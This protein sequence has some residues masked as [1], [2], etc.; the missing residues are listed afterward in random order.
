MPGPHTFPVGDAY[1]IATHMYPT[2]HTVERG[3]A[4]RDD[5]QWSLQCGQASQA[6]HGGMSTPSPM[7]VRRSAVKPSPSMVDLQGEDMDEGWPVHTAAS[8]PAGLRGRSSAGNEDLYVDDDGGEGDGGDTDAHNSDDVQDDRDSV[9]QTDGGQTED[10]RKKWQGMMAAAKL[11][12]DKCENASGKPSYWDMTMEERR[13]E[14]VPVSFEKELWEAMEWQLN[15]PSIKCDNTLASENLPG[16]AGGHQQRPVHHNPRRG[17]VV[18]TVEQRNIPTVQRR[19]GG[20]IPVKRG[21]TTRPAVGQYWGGRWRTQHGRTTK[22]WIR[23]LPLWRRQRRRPA[24][25]SQRRLVMEQMPCVG[26]TVSSKCL[27]GFLQGA[28]VEGTTVHSGGRTQTPR[29]VSTQG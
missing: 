21:W 3:G 20:R 17:N 14:Q 18:P 5:W 6:L 29:H 23:P 24:Q 26:G 27:W 10:C 8:S 7:S 13:A 22:V 25:R 15:R 2:Q 28:G 16:N 4:M 9:G 11:I 19:R 12:L 1:G